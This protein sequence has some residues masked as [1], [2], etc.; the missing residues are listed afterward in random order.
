MYE[1]IRGQIANKGP[2][3]L[4]LDVNGVGY[5]IHIPLS[6]SDALADQGESKVWIHHL[7]REDLERLYGFATQNERELFRLLLKV[8]GV[9]PAIALAIL[10]RASVA[11]ICEAIADGRVDFLKSLKGIG[12]KTAQRLITELKD[13]VVDLNLNTSLASSTSSNNLERDAIQALEVLGCAS[14]SAESAV[15]KALKAEDITTL[16]PLVKAALKIVWP[17]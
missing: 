3:R 10:S 1:F 6:T 7:V 8:S 12:P 17:S 16:E 14:K 13:R 4:I 15:K 9:G 11:D 2:T 5:E